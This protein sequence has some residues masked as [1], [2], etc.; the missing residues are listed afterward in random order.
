M[1]CY[2]F[3]K[4]ELPT[5]FD[6]FIEY[7]SNVHDH[8]TKSANLFYIRTPRTMYREKS[9][10][11]QAPYTFNSINSDLHDMTCMLSFKRNLNIHFLG[12]I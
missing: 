10:R 1:F 3:K 2:K 4:G 8:D 9:V 6:D 7:V 5:P 11:Y 12:T